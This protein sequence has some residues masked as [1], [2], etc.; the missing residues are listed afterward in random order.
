MAQRK[1]DFYHGGHSAPTPQAKKEGQYLAQ[2]PQRPPSQKMQII[3]GCGVFAHLAFLARDRLVFLCRAQYV[4]VLAVIGVLVAPGCGK[5]GDPRAPEL[6]TPQPIGNLAARSEPGGIVL[7][8]R[9]PT[10][11]KDGREIKD[12]A[13]FVIFRK[14]ILPSCPDCP[15]PY[16]PL[17][18]VPVEDRDKFVQQRQY[19][20]IDQ[21]V[22]P[23][24]TYRYRVSSQLLDGTL[25]EPSNE[26]AVT[27]GTR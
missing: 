10:E 2:S 25:S 15:V 14:E 20:Y 23:N 4:L 5:K 16:R 12:L 7:T 3:L 8:W 13:S 26:V 11:Y 9:R 6:A 1:R 18:T 27:R 24:A 22:R 19:R 17:V 21:E